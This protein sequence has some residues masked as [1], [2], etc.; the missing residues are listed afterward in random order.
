MVQPLAARERPLARFRRLTEGARFSFALKN[1]ADKIEVY[2]TR[3]DTL[4]GAS[5]VAIAADHP[6]A[7][8]MAKTDPKLAAFIEECRQTGTAE[9][10]LEKEKSKKKGEAGKEAEKAPDET[11]PAPPATVKP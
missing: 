9:A 3:P 10:E 11:G 6:I 5:F 7:A 4:Y 1:R 8:E 2:S